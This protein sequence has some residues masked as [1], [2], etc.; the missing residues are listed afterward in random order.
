MHSAATAVLS[1]LIAQRLPVKYPEGA[2]VAGLLHDLGRQMIAL[3]LTDDYARIVCM[4]ETG[5]LYLECEEEILGFTHAELSADAL[6]VWN[7]PEPIRTAVRYHHATALDDSKLNPG[8]IALSRVV[9]A[10][11]RYVNSVGI[12]ILPE[13]EPGPADITPMESLGL[14]PDRVETLLVEFKV[15][16]DAM[17]SFFR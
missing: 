6:D 1:D 14:E 2:F 15:E 13:S 12:S 16:Y 3:R 7:L 8:E 9:D 11:N 17:V 5:R 4:C 10:A